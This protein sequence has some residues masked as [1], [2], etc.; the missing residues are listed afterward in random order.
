[1]KNKTVL[2]V[3]DE[4]VMREGLA[5][6]IAKCGVEVEQAGTV[7]EAMEILGRTTI[8]VAFCDIRLS[9]DS[10]GE[11][12]LEM[13]QKL[14]PSLAVVLISCAIDS[15]YESRLLEKGA[16]LCVRKPL[17]EAECQAALSKVA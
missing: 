4:K 7:L 6:E 16:S 10:S 3:D 17:F 15:E 5:R 11:E 1:M 2:I 9:E 12:F 8:D 14:R 13:A